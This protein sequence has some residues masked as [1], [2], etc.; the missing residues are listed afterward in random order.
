MDND[1]NKMQQLGGSGNSRIWS[2]LILLAC[3]VLL[4][5]YKMGAPVPDWVFT[6]PVLLILIGLIAAIKS[7]FKNPGG[8]IMIAIGTI[9]LIDQTNPKMNFHDYI[10]PAILISVGIIYI[11]RPHHT[12]GRYE[13]RWRR[14]FYEGPGYRPAEPLFSAS[15]PNA[16]ATGTAEEWIEINAVFGSVKKIILSKN[17]KGGEINCFMGGAELNMMQADLQHQVSLEVNN[18][19]G[20][21]KIIVPSNWDVKNQATTVF[22]GIEDKRNLPSVTT[23]PGKVLVLHGTCVFGGI[24]IINY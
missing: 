11:L 10:L 1:N 4:L 19:F 6:W 3:G 12:F 14:K 5:A 21:T 13:R 8:L 20:G 15:Q 23:D 7:G 17:F 24:E 18:V 16:G 2:G 9:F 22:G